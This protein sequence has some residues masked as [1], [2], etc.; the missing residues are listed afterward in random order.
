MPGQARKAGFVRHFELFM[1][2]AQTAVGI[3]PDGT[4]NCTSPPEPLGQGNPLLTRHA[5]QLINSAAYAASVGTPFTAHVTIHFRL[6]EGFTPEK[7]PAFQTDLLDKMSRRLRREGIP[8]AF[9]WVRENGPVKGAHLHL[10]IH[11]PHQHWGAFKRYL[12]HAGRFTA[13]DAG[14]EAIKI[15]GGRFGMY[16]PSMRA[17]ACRYILK[18]MAQ[19]KCEA[20]GIRHKPTL[21]VK[22]KRCGISA[23]I[24]PKARKAA[25][26]RELKSL[27]E[28]HEHLHPAKATSPAGDDLVEDFRDAA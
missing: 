21:P 15:T 26:W 4:S 18:S 17:G 1:S 9:A 19:T 23:S 11:L 8:V 22:V 2:L 20:L 27:P 12:L 7:W 25:G 13:F 10:A 5:R 6:A 28:L 16:V 14:G 3:S 24:G